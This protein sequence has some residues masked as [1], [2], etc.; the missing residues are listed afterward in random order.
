MTDLPKELRELLDSKFDYLSL[1][2]KNL[3][4]QKDTQK[5]LLELKD[6][7][8]IETVLMDYGEWLTVCI[9]T[10]VGCPLKCQFCATG[11]M[12]FVRDLSVD[13]ILDQ[14]RYW[15][16]K[17]YPKYV[18]RIVFMG[19]GEPFLN[20]DNLIES[21]KYIDIGARKISISTAGIVPKII[22]F[23]NLK[24]QYNLAVSLHSLN[25]KTREELM[26]I[27][28]TYSI[29]ELKDACTYYVKTTRRQLFFEYALIKNINDSPKD[30]SLLIDFLKSNN[31]FY[32]NLITLNPVKNSKLQPSDKLALFE[33]ELTKNHI[34]FSIRASFGQ[35]LNAACGQL[36]TS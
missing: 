23:A 15:N 2:E 19:M 32:L 10:Q 11:N 14:V 35:N 4:N 29:K 36:A 12:G 31:L 9:S 5:A 6:A 13:E 28:K 3:L 17:L 27:A 1:S 26:P 8:K 30:Q 7:N 16:I 22:E 24:K 25:Q 18:G 20:W 34:N 21:L 33:K